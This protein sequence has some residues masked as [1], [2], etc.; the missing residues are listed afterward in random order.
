MKTRIKVLI[1]HSSI[2]NRDEEEYFGRECESA[3]SEKEYKIQC[4]QQIKDFI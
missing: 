2:T 1:D 4:P 3:D